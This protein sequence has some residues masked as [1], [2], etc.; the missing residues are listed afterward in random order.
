[1]RGFE[2]SQGDVSDFVDVLAHWPIQFWANPFW[3]LVGGSPKGGSPKGGGQKL[4]FFFPSFGL[5]RGILVVFEAPGPQMRTLEFSGCRVR[6]PAARSGGAG[7]VSHGLQKHHQN[8]T[9]T[10]RGRKE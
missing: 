6:A 3:D 1:M 10:K 9:R 8:S 2:D 5:F 4:R 7:G